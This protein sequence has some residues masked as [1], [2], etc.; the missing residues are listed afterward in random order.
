MHK[1]TIIIFINIFVAALIVAGYYFINSGTPKE[2]SSWQTYKNTKYGY[3][4]KYPAGIKVVEKPSVSVL[5]PMPGYEY[6]GI[7]IWVTQKF[8]IMPKTDFLAN[9]FQE[10]IDYVDNNIV[11]GDPNLTEKVTTLNGSDAI[12]LSPKTGGSLG[13]RDLRTVYIFHKPYVLDIEYTYPS[14]EGMTEKILST[15]KFTQ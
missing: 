13:E 6:D 1:K 9:N 10:V 3:E 15:I 4:L 14:Q 2:T 5:L 8:G 7:S 12:Y 11:A